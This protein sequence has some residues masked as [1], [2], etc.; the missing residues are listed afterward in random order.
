MRKQETIHLHALA[1]EIRTH[2][3][4]TTELP[5]ESYVAADADGVGPTAIHRRKEVHE[6]ALKRALTDVVRALESDA[7]VVEPARERPTHFD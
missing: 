2:L 1:V 4:E 5:V 6:A 7:A 3:R